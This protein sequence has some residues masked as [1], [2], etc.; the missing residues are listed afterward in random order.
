M[1]ILRYE[2][3]VEMDLAAAGAWSRIKQEGDLDRIF[4]QGSQALSDFFRLLSGPNK[5]MFFEADGTGIWLAVWYEQVLGTL[6]IGVWVARGRRSRRALRTILTIFENA[7][8]AFPAML[9]VT[10]QRAI[11]HILGRLGGEVLGEVPGMWGEGQAA[12]LLMMT[13][14]GFAAANA[15]RLAA[16]R[17]A[18]VES[19][20]E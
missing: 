5:G 11:V 2:P 12:W 3:G 8:R 14:E 1:T 13:R 7:L 10:K 4:P 18:E 6:Y 15:D 16:L 20:V 19:G 17:R 9:A